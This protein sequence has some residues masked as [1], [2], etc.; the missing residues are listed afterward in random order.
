MQIVFG[1]LLMFTGAASGSLFQDHVV[2]SFNESNQCYVA[3]GQHLHLQMPWEDGFDLKTNNSFILK[4]RKTQSPTPTPRLTRWQF[5]NDNKTMIL[6]S[7]ERSDSGTYTLDIYD[8]DGKLKGNYTLQV[9]IEAPVSSVKVSHSCLSTVTVKVNCS[10]DGDNLRFSW[11]SDVNTLPQLKNGSSIDIQEQNHQGNVTCHVENHVSRD[12]DT[13]ELLQCPDP[14]TTTTTDGKTSDRT[15]QSHELILSV[16]SV[17]VL[18]IILSIVA[19]YIFK[20]MHGSKNKE[21]TSQDGRELYAQVTDVSANTMER[22]AR[23]SQAQVDNVEYAVV[24]PRGSNKKQKSYEDE[25]QYGELVFNTP[26]KNHHP[27]PKVQDDCV[28]SQVQRGS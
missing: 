6:T 3:V 23:T 2:C 21:A 9:N 27:M 11:T 28:Y 18:L 10:A 5:V 20:R 26:A 13:V 22:R 12:H 14:T 24:V 19:I 25:V 15:T 17:C 8:V 4:Y 1:I 16:G 7:A